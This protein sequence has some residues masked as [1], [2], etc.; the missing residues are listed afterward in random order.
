MP[1]STFQYKIKVKSGD[2]WLVVGRK[3]SGKTWF[4]RDLID[5]LYNLYPNDHIYILDNKRRDFQ[6][7]PGIIQGDIAPGPIT[8]N[9][10]FQVWQP[11]HRIPEEFERW[12]HTVMQDAPAILGIDEGVYL[13]YRNNWFSDMI[14]VIQKTG[15]DLPITTV[16][17]TQDLVKIN[18]T[19][20]SQADHVARFTL[21][22]PYERSLMKSTIGVTEEPRDKW[23]FWYTNV[24][25][26]HA[27]LYFRNKQEFF[28]H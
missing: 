3:G 4:F 5:S 14:E 18:H 1:L 22:H 19:W 10:V 28:G 11:L 26:G 17:N 24:E 21:L 25:H 27:P 20:I 6:D 13:R 15:R 16:I 9:E 2:N 7:Y 8:G 23:G 12:M